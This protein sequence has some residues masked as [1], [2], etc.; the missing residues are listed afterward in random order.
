MTR[1]VRQMGLC[2]A[3]AIGAERER[4][5]GYATR[6]LAALISRFSEAAGLY[7]AAPAPIDVQLPDDNARAAWKPARL[8][9][10]AKR[11]RSFFREGSYGSGRCNSA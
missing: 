9:H 11:N 2:N 8:R 10:R 6:A 5:G 1:L 7:C 4:P 3:A